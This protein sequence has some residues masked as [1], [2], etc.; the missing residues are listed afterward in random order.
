MCQIPKQVPRAWAVIMK[1]TIRELLDEKVKFLRDRIGKDPHEAL[2]ISEQQYLDMKDSSKYSRLCE[3]IYFYG[4][5]VPRNRNVYVK[6]K[7]YLNMFRGFLL[8]A[9]KADRDFIVSLI[10]EVLQ[11]GR[12][13]AMIRN[14]IELKKREIRELKLK[15]ND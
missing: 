11:K 1:K 4:V 8:C 9:S 2:G 13:K 6:L 10:D 5:P 3:Y 15:L 12:E 14:E 7:P